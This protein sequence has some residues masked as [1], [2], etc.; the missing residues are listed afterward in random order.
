MTFMLSV[1]SD[2]L[3]VDG[4]LI[5]LAR[6]ILNIQIKH[7]YCLRILLDSSSSSSCNTSLNIHA[8]IHNI[9]KLCFQ[10]NSL[11]MNRYH[12]YIFSVW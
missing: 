4:R 2:L 10:I 8:F 11:H 5:L 12:A 6:V 7:V 3:S 1:A 9:I